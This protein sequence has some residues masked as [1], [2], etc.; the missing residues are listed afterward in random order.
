MVAFKQGG[1]AHGRFLD[2][3]G[4]TVTLKALPANTLATT[5]P[6]SWTMKDSLTTIAGTDVYATSAAWNKG[7]HT[8]P[9]VVTNDV[10][11]IQAGIEAV[12][13]T[14]YCYQVRPTDGV[15]NA[16]TS[17]KRCTTVPLDDRALLGEGWSRPA[18]TGNF[19]STLTTTTKQ[20]RVLTRT[21]VKAKRLALV[22][23]KTANSGTV[24]VSF[25]GEVLGTFD[26]E[27]TG[28]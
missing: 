28:K 16:T 8:D 23:R 22:V 4:P 13:G 9:E 17:D 5:V 15:G 7:A 20:G 12:P 24:R 10:A 6:L 1:S 27:G 19:R 2:A 21:G 11:G 18:E 26:L 3:S 25:D 14:T